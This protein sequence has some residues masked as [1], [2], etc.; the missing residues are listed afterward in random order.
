MR[1]CLVHRPRRQRDHDPPPVRPLSR[2]LAHDQVRAPRALPGAADADADDDRRVVARSPTSRAS[3]RKPSSRTAMP[4]DQVLGQCWT[5][6][7]LVWSTVDVGG[8][9]IERAPEGIRFEPP[10]RGAPAARRARRGREVRGAERGRQWKHMACSSMSRKASS[11][12]QPLY[13]R[14]ANPARRRGALLAPA[15]R[16]GTGQPLQ[17]DRRTC[18]RL[19]PRLA[20]YS[21]AVVELFVGQEAKGRVRLAP[22]P[23]ARRRGT[24]PRTARASGATPSSTGSRA[25]SAPK[26]GKVRIE[27][28][29]ARPGRDLARDRRVLRGRRRSTSTTTRS[30]ST[31]RRTRPRTSPSRARPRRGDRRSGAG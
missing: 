11:S 31:R 24:S 6:T 2:R 3:T 10:R 25:A 27:N 19:T 29:L 30:R 12:R 7:W 20:G 4:R 16:R 23:R 26:K 14:I 22:E 18:P 5:S 15:R 17:P 8:I 28:D 21:N 1:R 9:E 13:V